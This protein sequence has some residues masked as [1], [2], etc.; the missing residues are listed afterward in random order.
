MITEDF[1]SLA[2][3]TIGYIR[4]YAIPVELRPIKEK[5]RFELVTRNIQNLMKLEK[6][7]VDIIIVDRFLSRYLISRQM[8]ASGVYF[9]E[10]E[11]ALAKDFNHVVFSKKARGSRLKAEAFNRGARELRKRGVMEVLLKNHGIQ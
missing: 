5:L 8:P 7:R 10:I 6:E 1:I 11:P 9:E 3:Y 2:D 4:G